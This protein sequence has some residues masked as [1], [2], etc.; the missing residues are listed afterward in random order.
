M[1]IVMKSGCPQQEIELLF[2]ELCR[3]SIVPEV[4][5]GKDK[6]VI[7]LVGDTTE[8]DAQEVQNLS[9][10]IEQVLRINKPLKRASLEFRYGE[11]N[12]LKVFTPSTHITFGQVSQALKL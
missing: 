2:T 9:P 10:F 11:T 6:V 4:S 1:I 12:D 8:I 7:I 3:W 5:V